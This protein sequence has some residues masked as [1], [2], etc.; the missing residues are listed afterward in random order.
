MT[1]AGALSPWR[2]LAIV[3]ASLWLAACARAPVESA[4]ASARAAMAE[5]LRAD[6]AVLASEEFA[7]RKP[8][9]PGEDQ[10][11]AF[12]ERRMLEVGLMTGTTDPGS[13]W[14]MPVS[15][16]ATRPLPGVV[17]APDRRPPGCAFAPRCARA[18]TGCAVAPG[19]ALLRREGARADACL[20]PLD[21]AA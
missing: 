17:P 9:T 13:Y 1:R 8:G 3:L 15:L 21:L 11:L 2:L 14:R 10:T 6:I 4:P 12:L 19:P 7:G 16:V 5:R 20:R 18:E